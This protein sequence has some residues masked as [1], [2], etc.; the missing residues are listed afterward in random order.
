M[1]GRPVSL[2]D[3]N[4]PVCSGTDRRPYVTVSDRFW[5]ENPIDYQL[6][7]CHLCTH[8]YLCPRPVEA[9]S[10]QFYSHAAYCPFVSTNRS[11]SVLD[12]CYAALRALNLRWKRRCV[13]RIHPV[14]GRLLDFGCGTGEFLAAMRE[15]GWDTHGIERDERAA[16]HASDALNLPVRCGGID[17]LDSSAGHFDV[18]TLWHVLEHVYDIHDVI[19]RLAL[20]LAPNGILLLAVPNVASVDAA[21]YGT[22]WVAYDA[23]RHVQ[24]FTLQSLDFLCNE[25]QLQRRWLAQLPLDTFFN[26]LLSERSRAQTQCSTID[27]LTKP[28]R[29][30]TTAARALLAGTPRHH[31]DEHRGSTLLTA[32][33]RRR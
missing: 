33:T 24:H 31:P 12:H 16:S 11:R 30:A 3:V 18:I 32:W 7:Q 29:M 21:R 10:G 19:R 20:L 14:Q 5:Q 1:K 28:C 4:C 2:E 9:V 17:L 25:H 26:V 13:E 6:V 22:T 27:L 15:G 23:P 8:V